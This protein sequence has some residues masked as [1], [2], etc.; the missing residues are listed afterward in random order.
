MDR[1]VSTAIEVHPASKICCLMHIKNVL[2]IS[3]GFYS[4]IPSRWDKVGS[5]FFLVQTGKVCWVSHHFSFVTCSL[6]LISLGNAPDT[7]ITAPFTVLS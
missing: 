6:F 7:P 5:M 3:L 4:F 1:M 2:C